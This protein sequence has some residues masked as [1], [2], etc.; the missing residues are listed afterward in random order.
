[1]TP[2]LPCSQSVM[3]LRQQGISS[4][5]KMGDIWL[6]VGSTKMSMSTTSGMWEPLLEATTI[7]TNASAC[8]PSQH[9]VS[10]IYSGLKKE[11][12]QFFWGPKECSFL[13]KWL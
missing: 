5:R 11:T 10:Y 3:D 1:M 9:L 13:L 6:S 8:L 7:Q 12:A 4:L 2:S